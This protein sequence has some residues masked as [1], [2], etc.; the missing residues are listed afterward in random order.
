LTILSIATL[1][2]IVSIG[3]KSAAPQDKTATA[4]PL[5]LKEDSAVTSTIIFFSKF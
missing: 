1:T 4:E 2:L 3:L 5:T